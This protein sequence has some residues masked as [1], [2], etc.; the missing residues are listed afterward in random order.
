MKSLP[1]RRELLGAIISCL[2]TRGHAAPQAGKSRQ[3][4]VWLRVNQQFV[5][6]KIS[7]SSLLKNEFFGGKSLN[8][9]ASDVKAT[10]AWGMR[11]ASNGRLYHAM[12]FRRAGSNRAPAYWRCVVKD[13]RFL[14]YSVGKWGEESLVDTNWLSN[15]ILGSKNIITDINKWLP[16]HNDEKPLKKG[17]DGPEFLIERCSE[18]DQEI[19]DF[20]EISIMNTGNLDDLRSLLS[21]L[22]LAVFR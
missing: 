17:V 1:K 14:G 2:A 4:P 6:D 13:K 18:R 3:R 8:E 11:L 16:V 9:V 19:L 12:V 20:K 7:G 15:S 21:E 10:E 5:K 22:V